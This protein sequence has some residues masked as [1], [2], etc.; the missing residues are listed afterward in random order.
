MNDPFLTQGGGT[1]VSRPVNLTHIKPDTKDGDVWKWSF[2]IQREL[3]FDIAATVGY[4]G[5]KGSHT[6][7]SIG[8][9][10]QAVSPSPDTNTQA[11]RPFQQFYDP[12]MPQLGIQ[13]LANV[14]YLDS[15]GNSFYH[16]LQTKLDKRF[17]RG[18]SF[19]LAYTY[20]KA[21]GDGENGGQEGVSFQDP[22]D[23]L[24]SRGRFRFDQTHNFVAHYV[25]EL[26]GQSLSGP[27]KHIIGGWQSNGIISIRSGFPFTVTGGN[28][29]DGSPTRP[30]RIA[31]GELENPTRALWFDPLAFRRVTCN[32]PS[33]L[34]LCHYGSAGYNILES[35]GQRNLD[36]SLFKNF[37][38][39]ERF[40]LQFRSEF[41]NALNTP[42]FGQP[43]NIGF[44]TNNS[45]IPDGARQGEVRSLRNPMRIIQ[46][47]LKLFF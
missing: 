44:A 7:N 26:P 4:V 42:Y 38:V 25:W 45:I 28:L 10:N 29:N 35:P 22:R 39:T 11:R 46:F 20:S 12:A 1:A 30:D 5:S 18:V 24:G 2:D 13:T 37:Q 21:H 3:P 9:Y 41:F 8:N 47:G 27:L 19:G 40:K 31:D 15:Y 17:A 43:N 32:I 16:G 33:R 14:R 36:F 6:G 23:R 34:D